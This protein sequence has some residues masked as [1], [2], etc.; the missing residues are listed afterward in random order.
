MPAL[1][2][3]LPVISG[4]GGV[5]L[6]L[7]NKAL[8]V[9]RERLGQ[10]VKIAHVSDLHKRRFGR[11]NVQ[12]CHRI[13]NERPDIIIISG[14]LVSRTE[15]NF[16]VA[17][18]TLRGLCKIAPVYM[19]YGNHE[20]SISPEKLPE[21]EVMLAGTD[22]ILLKNKSAAVNIRGRE[23]KI[24]GLCESYSVYKKNE[25]YRDLDIVDAQE[26]SRLL[27]DCPGGEVLLIAHNPFFGR[28]YAEWGAKYTL[29]GHVHGG[30]VRLFGVGLLSPERKFLPKYSKGVY[31]IG[32]MKLLVSA[33][34][35]KLR[36]FDPPE[37]VM[38]EI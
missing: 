15:S 4:V 29:S 2:N 10:G 20:Q 27:G 13:K 6:L 19:I 16:S 33:G 5:S 22:V 24:Y 38:Y 35:G 25:S 3:I 12:L 18:K 37:I 26:L 11:D 34:L 28:A 21:F 14:D 1:K 9:R 7:S 8:T 36:L 23:L 31:T 30:A 17:E 32:N